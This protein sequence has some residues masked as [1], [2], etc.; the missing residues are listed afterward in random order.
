MSNAN[1]LLQQARIIGRYT[2]TGHVEVASPLVIRAGVHNDMSHDTIDDVLVA[3]HDGTPFIP[4]TSLAGVLRQSIREIVPDAEQV[5]FGSIDKKIGTQSALQIND[6]SLEN[7]IISLRDGICMDYDLGVTQEGLKFDFEVLEKGA[8][9]EFR[10]D[11]VLRECHRHQ[12]DNIQQGLITI[13]NVLQHGLRVGARTVNGLG[14]IVGHQV[15]LEHF[16]F[17]KPEQVQQ[18]LVGGHGEAIAIPTEAIVS[19]DD[20]IITID[21]YFE[22]TVFIKSIF[23]QAWDQKEW[24]RT[25]LFIPGTSIKGVLRQQCYR[26]LSWLGNS[27][28]LEKKMFGFSEK[29]SKTSH[30]GRCLVNEIYLDRDQLK[31]IEQ[32]RIRVDRFTGGVMAYEG[33]LFQDHPVRNKGKEPYTFPL[34]ITVKQCTPVEAGLMLLVMKDLMTGQMTFGAN[35]TIGCGRIRGQQLT[36]QFDGESYTMNESGT[37]TASSFVAIDDA[38][39]RLE[40]Y[41]QAFVALQ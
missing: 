5:L 20:L 40:S 36:V 4:G 38:R 27:L 13:G 29:D 19:H 32:A 12:L 1:Q 8:T 7:T 17:S 3:Y 21:G 11:C 9:G 41:V 22:D 24:S 34:Q 30:K 28:E 26:I 23:E 33:A 39:A 35:R 6:I 31:H 16:D 18:W 14:Q 25:D 37:I 15:V 10:I 2:L